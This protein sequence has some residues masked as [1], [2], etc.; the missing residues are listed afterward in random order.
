M[1]TNNQLSNLSPE[2]LRAYVKQRNLNRKSP[3]R[4][5]KHV[6]GITTIEKYQKE[7]I[8]NPIVEHDRVAIKACHA[9]GKTFSLGGVI[10]PWF[11]SNYENS[12]VITTAPTNRQVETLLWGEIRKAYKNSKTDLGGKL[13]TKKWTI[14]DDW[15]AMG[16]SPQSAAGGDSS[17]QQGSSFQGF[18]A[19]Y[20]LIVFDEATGVPKDIYTMAEGLLTSGMIVKWVCI[21]NPTSTTSEFFNICRMSEWHVVTINCFDSPNL[22]ANGFVNRETLEAE[23]TYLKTL[24]DYDRMKHIKNYKKPNTHLL[25]AQWVVA[26]IF[27]W[28]FDHPLTKSKILGEFPNKSDDVV[29]KWDSVQKAINREKVGSFN[30]RY[31]GV[32]VARFGDDSTVIT[33]LG[34]TDFIAKYT[35][36]KE[37]TMETAGRVVS[38]FLCGDSGQETHI[39]IDCT[40]VGAGVYDALK[41]MKRS[42]PGEKPILP[43]YVYL[44]EIHFGMKITHEN[45]QINEEL[46]NRY[47]NTKA[48]IFDLLNQDCRDVLSLPDEE[49]YQTELVSIMYKYARSGKLMI[50]NKDDYKKRVRKSPDTSDS[51]VLAN[52]ARYLKP[53]YG[54]FKGRETSQV[55][56][57][58]SSQVAKKKIVSKIKVKTY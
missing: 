19:K 29:V 36:M 1:T 18:H 11:T 16:F 10:V 51:L 17:E 21:A 38:A 39:A 50:E 12:I 22:I 6:L 49:I 8:F 44:H 15:Y 41:E 57:T 46:N 7:K 14:S 32:D 56:N 20:V 25:S 30:R 9:V 27:E 40:G 58:F 3:A 48:Y 26:K 55:S 42:K 34:D 31:F 47:E 52:Y 43:D 54:V 33:E 23:I 45:E 24:S 37:D 2:E 4:W 28:G 13:L 53:T 35:S 5:A